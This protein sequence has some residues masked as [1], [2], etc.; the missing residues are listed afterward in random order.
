MIRSTRQTWQ[1]DDRATV[2]FFARQA[3][4]HG[5]GPRA[6]DWGS[7]RSQALRFQRLAAIGDLRGASILD[8]GCGQADFAAWLDEQGIDVDYTGIDLTPAMV[9]TCRQRF[10]GRRFELAAAHDLTALAPDTW[11]YV[12]AC[13]LFYRRSVE[14]FEFLR[15]TVAGFF[16]RCRR[17]TAFNSLSAWS[18]V[19]DADEYYAD[20]A[21][22]L[23]FCRSLT[24][25]VVL[26]HAYHDRDF[27]V[28]LYQ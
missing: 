8:V 27:T 17:G 16:A 10:P 9:D 7:A 18:I 13:G 25:R 11:D 22:V 24:S 20:P 1:D 19:R 4:E 12:F 23:D 15:T 3:A 6:L 14:P 2:E 26:D 28:S 5:L 21:A